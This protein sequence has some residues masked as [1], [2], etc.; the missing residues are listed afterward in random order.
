[1]SSFIYEFVFTLT[2][3]TQRSSSQRHHEG[4]YNRWNELKSCKY[5]KV[6]CHMTSINWATS[7]LLL[8]VQGYKL[9][10]FLSER[11]GEIPWEWVIAWSIKRC[12]PVFSEVGTATSHTVSV[13]YQEPLLSRW[14][15]NKDTAQFSVVKRVMGAGNRTLPTKF[16]RNYLIPW[17]IGKLG[18]ND[19]FI[20]ENLC[21]N[22]T[23]TNRI[24]KFKFVLSHSNC[25]TAIS[26]K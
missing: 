3:K 17:C 14:G 22:S 4:Y 26:Q 19:S 16:S 18:L 12:E 10:D 1:M 7:V 5:M 24:I 13:L 20:R 21:Y 2:V 11:L 6:K 8:H 23:E 9:L 15:Y 25:L